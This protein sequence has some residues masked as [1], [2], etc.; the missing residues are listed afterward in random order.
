MKEESEKMRK[1]LCSY[2]GCHKV[3]E[4]GVKY[5]ERH[6]NTDKEKY[7]E[8]KRKRMENEEEAR[9]QQFYNSKAWEGFRTAQEAAQFG[10]DIFEYYTTGRIVKAEQYHHIEE[11][12]EAWYRRLDEGNV[13][14]LS[15]ANHRRIHKEYER[16]YMAKRKM[17]H[18]LYDMLKRF[19]R[20]FGESGGI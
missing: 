19:R 14:G 20:E 3:V 4:D 7:R 12:T 9:R 11:I 1:K 13:I 17:Q 8:Y 10:I 16:G 5:C 18:A 2:P 15:E 6:K